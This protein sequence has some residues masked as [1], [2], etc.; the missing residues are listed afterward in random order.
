M[1]C[2]SDGND[3]GSMMVQMG[4]AWDY[5]KYSGDYYQFEEDLARK[6]KR[7]IWAKTEEE[8]E[9]GNPEPMRPICTMEAKECP[10]W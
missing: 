6:E 4:M 8:P 5:S 1:H 10:G 2:T 7:G 9:E 3:V